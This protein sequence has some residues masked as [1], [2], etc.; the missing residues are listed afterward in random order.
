MGIIPPDSEAVG[1][2]GRAACDN[3]LDPRLRMGSIHDFYA[4]KIG[5]GILYLLFFWTFIPAF[6][7]FIQAIIALC[8]TSDAYGRIAI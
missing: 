1:A 7:A 5:L 6:A 8:K 2:A 4:G 3:G